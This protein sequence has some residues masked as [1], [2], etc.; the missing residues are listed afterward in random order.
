MSIVVTMRPPPSVN[1]SRISSRGRLISSPEYRRW[2]NLAAWDVKVGMELR[3]A[4]SGRLAASIKIPRPNNNSDIDNRVKPIF[5]ALQK[6]GA[7][8]ND[9]QFIRFT[10]AWTDK[11]NKWAEVEIHEVQS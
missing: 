10:V 11:E 4:L 8:E 2:V 3:P 7:I 9:K 5:D 1:S 6:G